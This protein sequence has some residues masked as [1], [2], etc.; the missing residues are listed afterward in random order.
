MTLGSLS[1]QTPFKDKIISFM[2]D[3]CFDFLVKMF[4][5]AEMR[6]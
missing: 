4:P 6:Y 1:F 5:V 3:I 2:C